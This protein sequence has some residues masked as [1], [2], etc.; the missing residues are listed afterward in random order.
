MAGSNPSFDASAVRTALRTAMTMG[1]PGNPVDQ[2]TFR[3]TPTK[4]PTQAPTDPSGVPYD[5]SAGA[6]VTGPP[7]VQIPA[8]VRFTPGAIADTNV[9]EFDPTKLVLEVLDEDFVL[10]TGADTVLYNQISYQIDYAVSQGLFDLTVWTIY[11]RSVSAGDHK[12]TA[13]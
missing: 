13:S 1:A 10:V 9:G 3:W 11:C 8:A 5:F 2:V 12:L 6:L 4:T 7:D